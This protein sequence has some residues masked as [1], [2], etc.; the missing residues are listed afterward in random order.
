MPVRSVGPPAD[1]YALGTILYELL[2]GRPPFRGESSQET[3]RQVIFD[4]PVTPSRLRPQLPR[5]LETIC[6][7]C[8]EKDPRRRYQLGRGPR[9][10]VAAVSRRKADQSPPGRPGRQALALG[11]A[12]PEDCRLD[13]GRGRPASASDALAPESRRFSSSKATIVSGN[14]TRTSDEP[15]TW[16]RI[17][18]G[19]PWTRSEP[20]TRALARTLFY[21]SPS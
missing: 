19:S 15:E 7:K 4:E 9:R 16:P 18:R 21:A 17:N 8:L 13:G 14:S 2:T 1:V 12:R 11:P 6:L 5:D 10:R 20:I 3:I